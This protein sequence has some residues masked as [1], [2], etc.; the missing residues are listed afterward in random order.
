MPSARAVPVNTGTVTATAVGCSSSAAATASQNLYNPSLL[1]NRGHNDV[2]TA[3]PNGATTGISTHQIE[4]RASVGLRPH[5]EEAVGH[6]SVLS[7]SLFELNNS[8]EEVP[9]IS[10]DEFLSSD[11][12]DLRTTTNT[13]DLC[14]RLEQQQQQQQNQQG[15]NEEQQRTVILQ[16]PPPHQNSHSSTNLNL[17][18]NLNNCSAGNGNNRGNIAVKTGVVQNFMRNISLTPSPSSSSSFENDEENMGCVGPPPFTIYRR[19]NNRQPAPVKLNFRESAI[20]NSRLSI[21]SQMT[22][23]SDEELE[24]DSSVVTGTLSAKEAARRSKKPVPDE[25]KDEMYWRRRHK[26]NIAAKRSREARRQK[27]TDLS[28]R[29]SKLEMEHDQLKN[30]LDVARRENEELRVRLSKYENIA[31][32]NLKSTTQL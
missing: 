24:M 25:K 16:A 22:E 31:S 26:N 6:S 10:L 4:A 21:S 12:E 5:N 32:L 27:E 29:A 8:A 7:Q 30:E 18:E 2:T 9:Y 1:N 14:M 15:E 20:E 13:Q 28:S 19:P 3:L 11:N 17:T 23:V